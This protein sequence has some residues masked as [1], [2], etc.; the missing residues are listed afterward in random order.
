MND[1]FLRACCEWG[2]YKPWSHASFGEDKGMV[3]PW[4]YKRAPKMSLTFA[5][6]LRLPLVTSHWNTLEEGIEVARPFQ[7][8][9]DIVW[10]LAFVFSPVYRVL[11]SPQ[12]VNNWIEVTFLSSYNARTPMCKIK[13]SVFHL[14][15]LSLWCQM[16]NCLQSAA[17]LM[18]FFLCL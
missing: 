14:D 5:V 2:I 4:R 10:T 1:L 3:H 8:N 11:I 12:M 9:I 15:I 17:L 6:L 16:Y 13:I 7:H 18:T